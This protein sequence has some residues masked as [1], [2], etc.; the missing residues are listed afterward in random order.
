MRRHSE[1]SGAGVVAACAAIEAEITD[2]ADDEE[3]GSD[4]LDHAGYHLLGL[5]TYF[6]AGVKD[7]LNRLRR[8]LG[9]RWQ[10]QPD[11]QQGTAIRIDI[12]PALKDGDSYC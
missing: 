9:G 3:S 2:L 10:Q 11:L 5:R 6:T 4:R 7:S 12:L 8:I 1:G